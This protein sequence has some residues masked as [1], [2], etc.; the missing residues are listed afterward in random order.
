MM[1]EAFEKFCDSAEL[2]TMSHFATKLACMAARER[3]FFEGG[4]SESAARI[5]ELETERNKIY[6]AFV[7]RDGMHMS[8]YDALAEIFKSYWELETDC[9][10]MA[11]DIIVFHAEECPCCICTIAAKY[12]EGK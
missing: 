10:A 11:E 12:W 1:N 5:A 4:Q 8:L 7:G 9:T 3:A 2:P 6:K